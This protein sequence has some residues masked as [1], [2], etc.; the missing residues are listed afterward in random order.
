MATVVVQIPCLNEAETLPAVLAEIPREIPGVERVLVLVVDDGSTDGT[1]EVARAGGADRVVR[2]PANRGLAAAFAAGI[3]A[4]LEMGADVVVNT[5]GDGQYPAA[6]IPDLV[7]PVLEERADMVIGDRRPGTVEHFSPLK[8]LLQRLGNAVLRRA[9]GT[10]VNDAASG[11]RALSRRAALRLTIVSDYT[12]TMETLLQAGAKHIPILSV[13]ITAREV[14]R[15]SRLFRSI[16]EY[17]VRVGTSILR[18][19]T[20]YR[21]LPVFV[22]LG[23][24]ALLFAF[25]IGLRFFWYWL[26]GQGTGKVQSLILAAILTIIGVFTL[27]LALVAD[28]IATNRRLLEEILLRVRTA[29]LEA[30]APWTPPPPRTGGEEGGGGAGGGP[31]IEIR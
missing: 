28:L 10:A 26:H 29:G 13:P 4:A 15:P 11:F 23:A 24:L 8:R 1:A 9:S 12:Y 31:P 6:A 3:E 30:R 16:P 14:A 2:F 18:I 22:R 27:L 20:M 25:L 5:D 17:L 19:F 7:R 21:P